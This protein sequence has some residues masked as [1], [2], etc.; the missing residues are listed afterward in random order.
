MRERGEDEGE[1]EKKRTRDRK[2]DGVRHLTKLKNLRIL[3]YIDNK[4][5]LHH[6]IA[7]LI[8]CIP[9]TYPTNPSR[10]TPDILLK[11][12]VCRCLS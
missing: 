5:N 12:H 1:G 2:R 9:C 10:M 11:T 7:V 6:L 4:L 3:T 8:N